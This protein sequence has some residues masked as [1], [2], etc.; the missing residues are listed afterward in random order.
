MDQ[1]EDTAA[2]KK[3]AGGLK[4]QLI[5]DSGKGPLPQLEINIRD[6]VGTEE[7]SQIAASGHHNKNRTNHFQA[8]DPAVPSFILSPSSLLTLLVEV[9]LPLWLSLPS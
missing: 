9:P 2:K 8:Q 5:S 7:S 3:G 4:K 6:T 1:A